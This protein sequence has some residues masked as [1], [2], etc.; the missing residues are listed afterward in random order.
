MELNGWVR[1]A[2]IT[3][4]TPSHQIKLDNLL[5]QLSLN[6]FFSPSPHQSWKYDFF[7]FT[8]ISYNSIQPTS[9][10]I[11]SLNYYIMIVYP[12]FQCIFL[13]YYY[14]IIIITL[15]EANTVSEQESASRSHVDRQYLKLYIPFSLNF[16]SSYPALL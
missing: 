7:F 14:A 8:F 12:I 13:K 2:L 11:L 10:I 9:T 5:Q 3:S 1:G 4:V 16:T 6:P 15:F